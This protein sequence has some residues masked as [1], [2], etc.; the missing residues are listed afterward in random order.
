MSKEQ[1]TPVNEDELTQAIYKAMQLTYPLERHDAIRRLIAQEAEAHADANLAS[2]KPPTIS[3]VFPE[4][5]YDGSN[6]HSDMAQ[7]V[8]YYEKAIVEQRERNV[9]PIKD[10]R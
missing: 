2:I 8:K 4:K 7:V 5:P 10:T 1:G 3:D 9:Y 6:A